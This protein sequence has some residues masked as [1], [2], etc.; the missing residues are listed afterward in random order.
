MSL[1]VLLDVSKAYV[2]GRNGCPGAQGRRLHNPHRLAGRADHYSDQLSGGEHQ[3]VAIAFLLDRRAID[4]LALD[5][6]G[7]GTAPAAA[8]VAVGAEN[9]EKS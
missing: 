4:Q 5:A 3:W 9:L 8:N 1:L 6:P 2:E 7:C